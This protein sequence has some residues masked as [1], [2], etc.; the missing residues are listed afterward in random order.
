[1]SAQA[2]S[3]DWF[4]ENNARAV[5]A[6]KAARI[7]YPDKTKRKPLVLAIKRTSETFVLHSPERVTMRLIINVVSQR[8]G[9]SVNEIMSPRRNKRAVEARQIVMYLA[10][11]HTSLSLPQIGKQLGGRD[12][13]TVLHG[14]GKVSESAA[15]LAL[16][17]A[18]ER[19]LPVKPE[20]QIST[21]GTGFLPAVP[22]LEF[23]VGRV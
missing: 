11:K 20:F 21:Y 14:V 3:P 7:I 4:A 22:A 16:A 19:D 10:R 5:A 6:L 13:S 8:T 2:G 23:E 12:H 15:L 18:L 17:T 1:M 9:I